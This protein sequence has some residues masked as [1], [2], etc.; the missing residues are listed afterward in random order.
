MSAVLN[1]LRDENEHREATDLLSG[2]MICSVT[3]NTNKEEGVIIHL[4]DGS[5][6]EVGFSSNEGSIL[7]HYP[8]IVKLS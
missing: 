1:S 6:L 4:S 5:A 2:K 7:Y 3:K 8:K